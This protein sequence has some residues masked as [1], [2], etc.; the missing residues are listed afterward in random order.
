MKWPIGTELWLTQIR[1]WEEADNPICV[2]VLEVPTQTD[3]RHL[4]VKHSEY[5]QEVYVPEERCFCSRENAI[6][7]AHVLTQ[8][9]DLKL[10]DEAD[11]LIE[12]LIEKDSEINPEMRQYAD[13]ALKLAPVFSIVNV[14]NGYMLAPSHRPHVY[15][16]GRESVVYWDSYSA[17]QAAKKIEEEHN[18]LKI[19]RFPVKVTEL[20]GDDES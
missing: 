13:K 9:K 17:D 20:E 8:L 6:R 14:Y 12:R 2:T 3:Q 11:F 5:V 18:P 16:L 10:D 7:A 19:K 15:T 1:Y 4:L